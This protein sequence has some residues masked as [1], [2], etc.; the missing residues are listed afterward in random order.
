MSKKIVT[1]SASDRHTSYT[2][3]IEDL[4]L[5]NPRCRQDNIYMTKFR[6]ETSEGQLAR[7]LCR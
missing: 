1:R 4:V 6:I 2:F 7:A 5:Y 3:W